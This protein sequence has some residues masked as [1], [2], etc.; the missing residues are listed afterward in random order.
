[1]SG[2]LRARPTTHH[3]ESP[4]PGAARRPV[5]SVCPEEGLETLAP[6]DAPD[7]EKVRN[8]AG[9]FAV[10]PGA[11]P[12]GLRGEVVVVNRIHTEDD[13]F[14][15]K[16]QATEIGRMRRCGDECAINVPVDQPLDRTR[17]RTALIGALPCVVHHHHAGARLQPVV[18]R[19]HPLR[20]SGGRREDH[21]GAFP[22]KHGEDGLPD[23]RGAQ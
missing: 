19:R 16:P 5:G 14:V 20:E 12:C 9:P 21:L 6:K 15:R 18:D 7:K 22:A 2:H 3:H 10:G 13:P 4:G 23:A 1:M 17:E 8:R 11:N